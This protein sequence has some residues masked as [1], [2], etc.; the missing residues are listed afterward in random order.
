VSAEADP[1]A[2]SDDGATLDEVAA[3]LGVSRERVFQIEKT[4]LRKFRAKLRA[5]LKD[6]GIE[7][8]DLH[9]AADGIDRARC[10]ALGRLMS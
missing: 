1:E 3:A 4:A 7:L 10:S 9:A 2:W 8:A 5:R 6:M